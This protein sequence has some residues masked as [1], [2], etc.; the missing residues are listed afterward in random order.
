M[1]PAHPL[2]AVTHPDPYPYY[3]A[4]ARGRPLYREPGLGLWIACR[5]DAIRAVL[6]H[7]AAR[8]RPPGAAVPPALR[9]GP[10]G[11]LFGRFV[12]MNDGAAQAR[13]KALLADFIREQGPAAIPPARPDAGPLDAA[14]VDRYVATAAVH[15]QAAFLGLPSGF[16]GECA[17]DIATFVSALP[18]TAGAERIAAADAAASRLQDRLEAYLLAPHAAPALRR[19]REAGAQAGLAPA[20]LAANLAGLLFQS[21]EAGAG[22]LGNALILAGRRGL[23]GAV[24]DAQALALV[25]ETLR[26]DPPVHNT[27]RFLAAPIEAAGQS[28][29]AGETVLLVLAAAAMAE[30]EAHWQFGALAH[31]C[32]GSDPA[33]RHA[34]A[35]LA[36][37]LNAGA[38]AVA[39]AARF[40]YRPL[41]NARV[42]L[43]HFPEEDTP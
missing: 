30:P 25:D 41:P 18:E 38:D 42:P 17:A 9:Q 21:C 4:L 27:R 2:A 32:P 34:A 5:P 11:T 10:A 37:L 7:S 26:K 24:T 35:S 28:I 20:L 36:H 40:R 15:A 23:R 33:R 19:L 29:E 31:A 22:L 43:F 13:A 8:V 14:A 1:L 12:R 39:L 6:R 16:H 3:A